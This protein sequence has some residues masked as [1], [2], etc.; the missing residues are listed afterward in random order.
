[1]LLHDEFEKFASYSEAVKRD[2]AIPHTSILTSPTASPTIVRQRTTAPSHSSNMKENRADTQH[3]IRYSLQATNKSF[4]NAE[5]LAPA[6]TGHAKA[7]TSDVNVTRPQMTM[8]FQEPSWMRRNQIQKERKWRKI[9]T[10]VGQLSNVK[11]APERTRSLFIHRVDLVTDLHHLRAY[12]QENQFNII[13]LECTSKEGSKY[14]SFKLIVPFHQFDRSFDCNLWPN[15][16]HVRE[17]I[18]PRRAFL[19]VVL[20]QINLFKVCLWELH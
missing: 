17:F 15:G 2:S 5:V 13:K 10:G 19:V 16:I 9:I 1:M 14:K 12:I 3:G 20:Y 18:P 7:N 8:V 6:V 11:G 4:S